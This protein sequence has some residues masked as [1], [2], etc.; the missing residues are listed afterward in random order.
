MS[1][2][3]YPQRNKDYQL[4]VHRKK[5]GC[6]AVPVVHS[7]FAINLNTN[8]SQNLSFDPSKIGNYDGPINDI[9]AFAMSAAN[10]GIDQ[11]ICN[12]QSYGYIMLPSKVSPSL[13]I[14]HRYLLQL[15]MYF[16][17]MCKM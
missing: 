11:Y 15:P 16:N 12:D 5:Q 6:Y 8:Y 17:Y 2:S 7:S 13:G 9:I 1:E 14:L 10:I 3:Y 4:I